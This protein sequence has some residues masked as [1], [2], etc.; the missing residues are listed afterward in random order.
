VLPGTCS[1]LEGGINAIEVVVLVLAKDLAG[2]FITAKVL[3]KKRRLDGISPRQK[4]RIEDVFGESFLD[5][6]WKRTNRN[7]IHASVAFE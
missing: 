6:T 4:R 2:V 1:R 7:N 3:P 5:Y